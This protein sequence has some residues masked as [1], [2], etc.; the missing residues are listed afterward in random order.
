MYADDTQ[1]FAAFD[2]SSENSL[3]CA[4]EEL[5]NCISEISQWMSTNRLKLNEENAEVLMFKTQ[6]SKRKLSSENICCFC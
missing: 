2:L 1:L 3:T 6:H 4:I 5:K